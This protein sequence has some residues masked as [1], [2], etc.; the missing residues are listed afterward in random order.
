MKGTT[1]G[2]LSLVQVHAAPAQ[3]PSMGFR[4]VSLHA[5]SIAE[6]AER[7]LHERLSQKRRQQFTRVG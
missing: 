1:L 4:A 6:A 3:R 2:F 5:S 7:F